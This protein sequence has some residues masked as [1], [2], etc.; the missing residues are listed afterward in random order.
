[1]S[2][3]RAADFYDA[4]RALPS[5]VHTRLTAVLAAEVAGRGPCLEIG[6]GTGRIALPLVAEGVVLVGVDIAPMMLRRLA[7]NAGGH[8]PFPLCVA[9]VTALPF[10]GG[11]YGAVL[12][13]HVLHLLVGW[14]AAVDEAVRVLRPG[15]VFLVDFGGAPAAPW[16]EATEA[17][18]KENGV[19]RRRPG[20]SDPAEVARHLTGR[21]RCRPLEPLTMTVERTLAQDLADWEGQRHSWTWSLGPEQIAAA[22]L[23]VRRWASENG[24][25]LDRRVELLRTIQWW[26]FD[27]VG[28][29]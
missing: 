15:G 20:T 6:V 2:F 11:R 21:A 9:D 10:S 19:T 14:G 23:G 4:T 18:L 27:V 3:D 28:A 22:A 25:P 26:A 17:V 16:H 12:A 5:E 24:W 29:D 7:H 13:S 8:P 1:M